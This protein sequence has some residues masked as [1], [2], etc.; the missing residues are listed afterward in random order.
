MRELASRG[1]REDSV[2]DERRW[3]HGKFPRRKTSAN[4]TGSRRDGGGLA[5][6]AATAGMRR[7]FV[8]VHELVLVPARVQAEVLEHLEI[9][10][11]R[12]IEGGEIIADH[13]RAGARGEDH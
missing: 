6:V 1:Q 7:G 5:G 12:L 9:L 2:V 11:H 10:F 13:Q 4:R 8:L 3:E